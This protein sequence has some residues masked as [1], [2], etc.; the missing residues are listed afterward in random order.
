MHRPIITI[1][2]STYNRA[3]IIEET[4]SSIQNQTYEYFEC[5]VTD[6]H[7][8]DNT[9]EIVQVFCQKDVR[10][11]YFLKPKEYSQGLSATRNFGLSLAEDKNAQY[12][13]FF[14]DDDIMHPK[15]LELQIKPFE[16][17]PLLEISACKYLGFRSVEKINF[18]NITSDIPI[19][20]NNLSE[21]F[22]F[23]KIKLNSAGPL[24]KA[25]L[26][27]KERFDEKLPYGEE[28]EFFAR[29]FFKYK[30][31]YKSVNQA[32]FYYRHH[33]NTITSNKETEAEKIGATIIILRKTWIFLSN[34]ELH[35]PRTIGFFLRQFLFHHPDKNYIKKIVSYISKNRELNY[36]KK[37]Q[38][39]L[40]IH[41]H[42]L[43]LR[44]IRS[45]F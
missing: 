19:E 10:F 42:Y 12:I 7:S 41:F 35:T 44:I 29:I 16:K 40:L 25:K 4:L 23:S 8:S 20:T 34:S 14:D 38:W 24:F 18:N 45:I 27:E 9:R 36:F 21:D 6:D 43:Y 1:L 32:L 33:S 2:L 3:H 11:H 31:K 22:L 39:R 26:F 15:K 13:Q 17:D 37:T 28:W 30:P 5:L